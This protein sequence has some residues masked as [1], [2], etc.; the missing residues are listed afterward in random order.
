[1][2]GREE[3]DLRLEEKTLSSRS[4]FKG[5]IIGLRI[6]E[7]E[8][9]DG[10]KAS[11]EIVEHPGAVAVVPLT[12]TGEVVMVEQYRVPAGRVLLEIPAGKLEPGENPLACARRE[13]LEETGFLA[14][15]LEILTPFYSTP[16]FCTELAYLVMATG[17]IKREAATDPDEFLRLRV[18]PLAD[19]VAMARRGEIPDAK[20]LLGLLW[21]WNLRQ[22]TFRRDP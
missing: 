9:P 16:G 5:R 15:N 11:R 13:L 17:L 19:T 18:L 4:V 14:E 3:T 22:G 8:L 20:T 2:K 7:V 6:D 1:M 12:E 21:A 10:R